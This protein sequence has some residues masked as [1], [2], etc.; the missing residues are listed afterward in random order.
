M[1]KTVMVTSDRWSLA[2]CELLNFVYRELDR[3]KQ[4]YYLTC[5]NRLILCP[6]FL[7]TKLSSHN[8]SVANDTHRGELSK[9]F[10]SVPS[11]SPIAKRGSK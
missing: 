3:G 4:N 10:D 6:D 11:H 9:S 8:F 7:I 1:E 5:L 2:T